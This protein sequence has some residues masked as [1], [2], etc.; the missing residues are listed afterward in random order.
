LALQARQDGAEVHSS[1]E[2]RGNDQSSRGLFATSSLHEGDVIV[3]TPVDLMLAETDDVEPSQSLFRT[4]TLAKLGIAILRLVRRTPSLMI[5]DSFYG[6]WQECLPSHENLPQEVW[7]AALFEERHFQAALLSQ[8][9]DVGDVARA[10]DTVHQQQLLGA[11]VTFSEARWAV[12]L[13]LSRKLAMRWGKGTLSVIVPLLDF[14]NHHSSPNAHL[15]CDWGEQG[16]CA[17]VSIGAIRSGEEIRWAYAPGS[18]SVT[19]LSIWG[20]AP[21]DHRIALSTSLRQSDPELKTILRRVGCSDVLVERS[22]I[23]FSLQAPSGIDE[24]ECLRMLLYVD[25]GV[26]ISEIKELSSNSTA[27]SRSLHSRHQELDGLYRHK[28]YTDCNKMAQAHTAAA[29]VAIRQL[30]TDSSHM[31]SARLGDALAAEV[32][33]VERCINAYGKSIGSREAADL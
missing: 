27:I 3:K 13:A 17:L 31:L 19:F 11:S 25:Y 2:L 4:D 15:V 12:H 18:S 14:A 30:I 5:R 10:I 29:L 16:S 24:P 21:A 22:I 32:L 28:I 9:G 7:S 6:R 1:V 20:F 26:S 23:T 8:S 33:V